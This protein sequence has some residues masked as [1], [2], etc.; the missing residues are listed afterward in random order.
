VPFP[1]IAG[2]EG[3]GLKFLPYLGGRPVDRCPSNVPTDG[4]SFRRVEVLSGTP[5]RR[6]WTSEERAS[7]VA[8]SLAA[9][10]VARQVALRHGVHPNQLYA[11][12]REYGSGGV[13]EPTPASFVPVAMMAS[14]RGAGAGCCAGGIEIEVGGAIVRVVP[15]VDLGLL[16]AVLSVVKAA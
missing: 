11:W 16:R 3:I 8:E 10:K 14:L 7:I 6:R 2:E 12:R 15:G 4:Q 13:G 5:R 9:G 1:H